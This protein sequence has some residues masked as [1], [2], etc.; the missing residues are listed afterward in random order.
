MENCGNPLYVTW[1]E[2]WMDFAYH[3]GNKSYHTFKKAHDSMAKYPTPFH[4]PQEALCLTGVGEKIVQKLEQR[5]AQHCRENNIPMPVHNKKSRKAAGLP[6]NVPAPPEVEKPKPKKP[7]KAPVKK[8]YCPQYRSGSFGILLA[9]L[10]ASIQ[11]NAKSLTKD[12]IID[13]G[14]KFSNA[15]LTHAEHGSFYTAW[16]S[17]KT[18]LDHSYVYQSGKN[19]FMTELGEACAEQLMNVA[20]QYDQTMAQHFEDKRAP[21]DRIPANRRRAP[22][23]SPEPQRAAKQPRPTP[24]RKPNAYRP[25]TA[26]DD[27]DMGDANNARRYDYDDPSNPW[28][29]PDDDWGAPAPIPTA[30]TSTSRSDFTAMPATTSNPSSSSLRPAETSQHEFDM[31]G[32]WDED[33]YLGNSADNYSALQNGES[34]PYSAKR[35][36][37]NTHQPSSSTSYGSKEKES[38]RAPL[39]DLSRVPMS[40]L[41]E[42]AEAQQRGATSSSLDKTASSTQPPIAARSA[43]FKGLAKANAPGDGHDSFPHLTTDTLT[44]ATDD[45]EEAQ[46]I[47]QLAKFQPTFFPAGSFEIVL[48]LDVREVRVQSDR[49]YMAQKLKDRGINV[50]K[51]ALDIGDMIWVAARRDENPRSNLPKE[52]V[53]DYVVERKRM[54]DLVSSIKDGRFAEQ[55]FRLSRSGLGQVIYL[56]ETYKQGETYDIGAEAIRTAMTSTQVHE[57]FFLKRTVNMDHTIDYLVSMTK[58]LKDKYENQILYVIPDQVVSRSSHIDLLDHLKAKSPGRTFMT[59]Y[60]SFHKLNSKSDTLT[61][62]DTFVKV[63]M[64]VRGLSVDK[65]VEIAKVYGSPR[66]LFSA[67][68]K[69]GP[70]ATT[71]ERRDVLTRTVS[72]STVGRKKIGPALAKKIA[73]LWYDVEYTDTSAPTFNANTGEP[74]SQST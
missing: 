29:D 44:T 73:E 9:L 51:R 40:V 20:I 32:D 65:A 42:M 23:L 64:T 3:H 8:P 66:A 62:R 15:S 11:Q 6:A 18:L 1:L 4:H 56:I 52:V 72:S 70:E 55:K 13:L 25:A 38:S 46:D 21:E 30:S 53:L 59:S 71:T 37:A 31:D 54:D 27:V 19:F 43:S 34:K 67:L 74:P 39:P 50:V 60:E 14:Q 68:D 36:A 57:G 16:S 69:P 41:L 45:S 22:S 7:R 61:V 63:L 12:E 26:Y 2:E 49:D 35:A 47:A 58:A 17:M 28:E 48:V 33:V 24:R 5:L 10:Q